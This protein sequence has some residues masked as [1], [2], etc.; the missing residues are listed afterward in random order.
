M[1]DTPAESVEN[2]S[3]QAM[4]TKDR[5][6]K[7][8]VNVAELRRRLG[9][10]QIEPVHVVLAHQEVVSSR[11]TSQPVMGE[12]IIESIERGVSVNGSVRF[13]WEGD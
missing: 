5:P 3:G 11:A 12:V 7:L 13:A 8:P 4:P 10:R 1:A 2:P 9:Q 6:A